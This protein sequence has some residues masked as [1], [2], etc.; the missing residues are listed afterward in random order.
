MDTT[1]LDGTYLLDGTYGTYE[2]KVARATYGDHK[3]LYYPLTPCCDATGKGSMTAYGEGCVACR[4][5]HHEVD[6]AFGGCWVGD[7]EFTAHG[8]KPV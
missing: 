6:D 4:S 2:V 8:P 5:C 1:V 3:P 7:D